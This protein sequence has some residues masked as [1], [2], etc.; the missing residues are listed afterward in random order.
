MKG[1]G[2]DV[3]GSAENYDDNP[4]IKHVSLVQ[5]TAQGWCL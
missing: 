5:N 3:K 4:K 1:R 2:F